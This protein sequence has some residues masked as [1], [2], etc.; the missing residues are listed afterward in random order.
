MKQS[1]IKRLIPKKLARRLA[2][3][4]GASRTQLEALVE[5]ESAD[6]IA[7][8][9]AKG[10]TL[11]TRL[12]SGEGVF[13]REDDAVG[14]HVQV[15]RSLYRRLEAECRRREISK[16]RVVMEALEEHLDRPDDA[17]A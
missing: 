8:M 1:R 2:E 13:V 7:K 3:A 11:A 12:D 17:A 14:L 5:R 6:S 16:K 15:P 10:Y 4:T 9:R